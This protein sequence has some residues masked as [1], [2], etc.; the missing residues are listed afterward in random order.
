MFDKLIRHVRSPTLPPLL[1]RSIGRIVTPRLRCYEEFRASFSGRSGLELGGPSSIFQ[2]RGLFPVYPLARAV[3]DC[4]F[5]PDTVWEGK[6]AGSLRRQVPGRQ[7]FAEATD[8][9]AIPAAAYDFVLSSHMLEHSANPLKALGEWQRVL[10]P[11][12][13]LLLVLPHKEGTFDHR[14]PVTPLQ[15][16]IQD[17]EQRRGEDDLTHLPEILQLHDLARDPEAG[18][19]ESFRRRS[20]RN[21]ENRCLHHHVFDTRS[22]VELVDL[23]RLRIRAVEAVP[24]FHIFVLAAN[25]AA[26]AGENAAFLRSDSPW[27]RSSPFAS[28]HL[29]RPA[30]H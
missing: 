9:S 1:R 25:T 24:P 18:D 30:Q 17:F 14:R 21:L 27:R 29:E 22:A 26:G 16:L 7:F 4:N 5:R 15:H 2:P 13:L 28:D 3:D 23:V 6:D 11:D 12:G 8:L 10:K 19:L 20:Q